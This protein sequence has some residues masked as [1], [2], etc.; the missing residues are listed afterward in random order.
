MKIL[1]AAAILFAAAAAHAGDLPCQLTDADYQSLAQSSSRV[2][3]ESAA[4]L[5]PERQQMLCTTRALYHEAADNG[6]YL[7]R[8]QRYSPTFLSAPERALVNKAINDVIKRSF[9]L[10]GVAIA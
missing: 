5:S 9:G 8:S 2:S 6:G 1:L 7:E 4:S 10:S 3:P